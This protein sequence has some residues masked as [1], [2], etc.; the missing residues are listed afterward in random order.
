MRNRIQA[1]VMVVAVVGA[2]AVATRADANHGTRTLQVH[3]EV[4]TT[5]AAPGTGQPLTAELSAAVD[6]TSG[7]I[8]I[9]FEVESGPADTDGNS[10]QTP[11]ATCTVTTGTRCTSAPFAGSQ[12]GTSTVRAWIDHDKLDGDAGG[13]TEADS[14]EARLSQPVAPPVVG[15]S[16]DCGPEDG[17][18]ATCESGVA[19]P[20]A[21]AEPDITDVVEIAYTTGPTK[22]DCNDTTGNDN[23]TNNPVDPEK[24]TCT[25]LDQFN[26]PQSNVR[27]DAENMNGAND[28]DDSAAAGTTDYNPNPGT[29]TGSF[30]T[31]DQTGVCSYSIPA[32]ETQE[33]S[34]TICFWVDD[35]GTVDDQN[36]SPQG[37][38]DKN[39]ADCDTETAGEIENNDLTDV[40]TLTW[41]AATPATTTTTTSTTT[42]STTT[43]STTTTTAPTTTTSTSTTTTSS[44]T[45]TTAAPTTTTTAAPTTTTTTTPPPA[46]S[47][48]FGE[49]SPYGSNFNGGMDIAV[50]DVDG[51]GKADIVTGAGPGG[52]PHVRVWNVNA[53]GTVSPSAVSFFAYGADFHGGVNVAVGDVNG[54]G[55]ADIITGA[56][57]GGGPH[58]RVFNRDGSLQNNGF[59]AYG[60]TFKGGVDVAVGNVTG[61]GVSEI[62]TAAG[63]GGGPHVRVWDANAAGQGATVIGNGFMAYAS[64]FTGGVRVAAD[65]L[66]GDQSE[67]E[68]VTGPGPGGGPHIRVFDGVTGDGAPRGNGFMAYSQNFFGGVTVATGNVVGAAGSARDIITGAGPGGGPHVRVFGPTGSVLDSGYFAFDAGYPG[69]VVVAAGDVVTVDNEVSGGEVIAG[70][71][72]SN[73]LIRGR[74]FNH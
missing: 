28:P 39:G 37:T 32:Q 42:T 65:N 66:D 17:P 40:V 38:S 72:R 19:N 7:P 70:T 49:F 23:E 25:V 1:L 16:P 26:N 48:P 5:F 45:T 63:A 31:T 68:I 13:I 58:V 35:P 15:S 43:T 8:Q 3:P 36:F 44:S 73:S 46:A 69:G 59:M 30:C 9:D 53:N 74:R 24:Y 6:G 12:T 21:V 33:G 47:Q 55:K 34:A 57:A 27:V 10:R 41:N 51:D 71:Y 2:L 29:G 62:V 4:V 52:G 64:D 11:D 14:A 56:G 54:D 50:G 22:L 20:G 67:A 60:S 61:D 18:K